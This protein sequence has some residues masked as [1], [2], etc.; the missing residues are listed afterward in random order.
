MVVAFAFASDSWILYLVV[1]KYYTI[2]YLDMLTPAYSHQQSSWELSRALA[3]PA[4]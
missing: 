4:H 2:P 3:G 1:L